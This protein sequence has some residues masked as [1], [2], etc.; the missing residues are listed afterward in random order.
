[1]LFRSPCPES[2]EPLA[3]FDRCWPSRLALFVEL[4]REAQASKHEMLFSSV[5]LSD[6]DKMLPRTGAIMK[7]SLLIAVAVAVL[8]LMVARAQNARVALDA[9]AAALGAAN[10]RSIEFSGRGFDF[11]FGQ[12]YDGNSAW[13]RF[14]V[15]RY[16]V[17]IDYAAQAIRDDRTRMQI[18][19]PPLGGGF[20]P[21]VGELRQDRK[22][23]RLNSSHIQKSRM[24]SSA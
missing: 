13:P 21:I 14:S 20:Q 7:R 18:Q 5:D 15:P 8:W 6:R 23:T 1:M 19:N 11:M 4:Q 12:A 16:T 10:L 22:S 24:P 3:V 2:S 17:T 9:A